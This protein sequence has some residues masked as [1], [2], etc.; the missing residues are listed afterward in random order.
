[1]PKPSTCNCPG[2]CRGAIS[3]FLLRH[4]KPVR[5]P[6]NGVSLLGFDDGAKQLPTALC[7]GACER[8]RNVLLAVDIVFGRIVW[9]ELDEPVANVFN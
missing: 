9:V 8:I 2:G 3:N 4:G 6:A 5:P 1:M 7:P